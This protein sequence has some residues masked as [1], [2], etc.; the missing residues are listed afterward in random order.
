M[1][2]TNLSDATTATDLAGA[3]ANA[4]SAA[5]DLLNFTVPLELH[6]EILLHAYKGTAEASD[7]T[8]EWQ[9]EN[10]RLVASKMAVTSALTLKARALM[11]M[12][13]AKVDGASDVPLRLCVRPTSVDCQALESELISCMRILASWNDFCEVGQF[14]V[15][16]AAW[17]GKLG[18]ALRRLR[19]ATSGVDG[20]DKSAD[21]VELH[22]AISHLVS[23]LGWD[24]WHTRLKADLTLRNPAT[25]RPF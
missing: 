17:Q 21:A 10:K 20:T 5:N 7:A 25:L 24:H 6:Q 9:A 22:R 16:W 23:M 2:E 4:V 12:L 8:P 14:A 19:E 13:C 1:A 18:L 15:R 11:D 3:T